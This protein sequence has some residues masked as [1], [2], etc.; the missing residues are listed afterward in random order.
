MIFVETD[1][2]DFKPK[3]PPNR[4]PTH[5]GE[6][7]RETIEEHLGIS[8]SEAARRMEVTRQALHDVLRGE[9]KVTADMA[10]RFSAIGG[11]TAEL[12]LAMQDNH[13]LWQA[14]RRLAPTLRRIEHAGA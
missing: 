2:T 11:G 4:Q 3:R 6:L 13:D 9:A 14:R 5:P 10:L 1:M 8:I 7:M 12:L